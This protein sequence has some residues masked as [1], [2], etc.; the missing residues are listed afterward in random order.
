MI[1]SVYSVE[2]STCHGNGIVFF[3]DNEDYHIDPC[4]CVANG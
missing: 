3:G 1:N 4:E 2:C